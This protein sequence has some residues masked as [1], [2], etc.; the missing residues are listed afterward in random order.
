MQNRRWRRY[1][2][3]KTFTSL[4]SRGIHALSAL[5]GEPHKIAQGFALGIFVGM[6]PTMGIQMLIAGFL[7]ALLK[8]NPISAM[9]G[10]WITTP[11][12]APVIYGTTYIVG[13]KI[14]TCFTGDRLPLRFRLRDIF[15]MLAK[16]PKIFSV[17]M[18]GG[19]LL[20]LPLAILS[21]YAAL[22]LIKEY[23]KD[24]EKLKKTLI[25]CL[26]FRRKH[27][28]ELKDKQQEET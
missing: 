15:E 26:S 22:F 21:Y 14:Y 23:R 8:W 6:T 24:K 17:L 20:G 28:N 16:T 13:A 5:E 12:T 27:D 9:M 2:S 25:R 1:F 4:L 10:V 18:I 3:R 19:V 11:A 7:A